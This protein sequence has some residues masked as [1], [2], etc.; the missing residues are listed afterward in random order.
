MLHWFD[1]DRKVQKC[2]YILL[3]KDDVLDKSIEEHVLPFSS[4][5]TARWAAQRECNDERRD[6]RTDL[7]QQTPITT[8]TDQKHRK[9]FAEVRLLLGVPCGF[10]FGFPFWFVLASIKLSTVSCLPV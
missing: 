9:P 1:L 4:M 10:R 2:L 6:E 3:T 5:A 7:L 8:N